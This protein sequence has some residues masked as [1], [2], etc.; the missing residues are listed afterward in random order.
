MPTKPDFITKEQSCKWDTICTK[1]ADS[2]NMIF[3]LLKGAL[4]G[5]PIWDD[6]LESGGTSPCRTLSSSRGLS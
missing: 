5:L 6:W 2:I 1:G 3:A 4:G